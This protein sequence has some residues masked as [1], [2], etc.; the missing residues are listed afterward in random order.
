M[1]RA[2]AAKRAPASAPQPARARELR[3]PAVAAVFGGEEEEE[4]LADL[5]DDDLEEDD[6]PARGGRRRTRNSALQAK[7][8]L[9]ASL[10]E[11]GRVRDFCAHFLPLDLSAEEAVRLGRCCVGERLC[12]RLTRRAG[13]VHGWVGDGPGA[14]GTDCRRAGCAR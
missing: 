5:P 14:V 3:D 2:P 13:R 10:G 4:E 8:E 1:G 7:L 12:G 6:G 9:L 11:A